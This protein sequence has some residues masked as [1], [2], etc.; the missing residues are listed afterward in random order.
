MNELLFPQPEQPLVKAYTQFDLTNVAEAEF[1]LQQQLLRPNPEDLDMYLSKGNF[2]AKKLKQQLIQ[3]PEVLQDELRLLYERSVEETYKGGREDMAIEGI[4]MEE[5]AADAFEPKNVTRYYDGVT[6]RYNLLTYLENARGMQFKR[7][8]E[9]GPGPGIHTHLME[10]AMNGIT[11]PGKGESSMTIDAFDISNESI[12]QFETHAPNYV[13]LQDTN[14]Q[15]FGALYANFA[16]QL[17][18]GKGAYYVD[19]AENNVRVYKGDFF[20]VSAQITRGERQSYDF[21]DGRNWAHRPE[22]EHI[23]ETLRAMADCVRPDGGVVYQEMFTKIDLNAPLQYGAVAAEVAEFYVRSV[24]KAS[25]PNLRVCYDAAKFQAPTKEQIL[26]AFNRLIANGDFDTS[27]GP[28]G[29]ALSAL[30]FDSTSGE[31]RLRL[32]RKP[33]DYSRVA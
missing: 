32:V 14:T 27:S 1:G 4:F 31:A 7:A 23:Y 2:D 20:D 33:K 10:R 22:P 18:I 3:R 28:N 5:F 21:L 17:A 6:R 26:E 13:N 16:N 25:T 29:Q 15:T 8:M 12:R 9:A 19:R 11:R 30:E 24:S